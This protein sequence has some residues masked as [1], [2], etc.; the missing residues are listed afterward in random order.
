MSKEQEYIMGWLPSLRECGVTT[1][2]SFV[3]QIF[4]PY[5]QVYIVYTTKKKLNPC[6]TCIRVMFKEIKTITNVPML[7]DS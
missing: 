5:L 3:F 4:L 7:V 1:S 2:T 6:V